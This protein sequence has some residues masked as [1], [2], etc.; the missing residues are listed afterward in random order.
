MELKFRAWFKNNKV[1]IEP[2]TL[3]E[4]IHQKVN[5][6]SLEQLND[7]FI[8]EQYTGLKDKN[9]RDI[10]IGD[11]FKIKHGHNWKKESYFEVVFSRNYGYILRNKDGEWFTL[12]DKIKRHGVIGN[13]HEKENENV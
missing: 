7:W 8:F 3:Q 1:Y 13:I 2:M 5:Q 11:V 9:G 10:Y 6:F 12:I 4:M